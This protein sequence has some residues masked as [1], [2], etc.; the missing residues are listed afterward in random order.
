MVSSSAALCSVHGKT[1]VVVGSDLVALLTIGADATAVGQHTARLTLDV[2]AQIPGVGF[3]DQRR[4]S[5]LIVMG[6]P[7]VLRL[8]CRFDDIEAFATHVG[9]AVIDPLDLLLQARGH[10]AERSRGSE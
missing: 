1:L 5:D 6:H 7:S 10:V 2:R 3:C 8:L 4:I 9:D